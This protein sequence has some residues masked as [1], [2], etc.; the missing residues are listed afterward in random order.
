[1][2]TSTG[3]WERFIEQ[4]VLALESRKM[5]G[6]FL[7]G[8]SHGEEGKCEQLGSLSECI[9]DSGGVHGCV[10]CVQGCTGGRML[11]HGPSVAPAM[12]LPHLPDAL[13]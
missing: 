12:S 7:N 11:S 9:C 6:Y 5:S 10:W 2:H 3:G 1:M 13:D 8:Y 4:A